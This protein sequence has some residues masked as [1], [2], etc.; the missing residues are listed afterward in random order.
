MKKIAFV[1]LAALLFSACSKDSSESDITPTDG[2]YITT[3]S[4]ADMLISL[5]LENGVCTDFVVYTRCERFKY[6]PDNI[7]TKGEYP[8]YRYYIDDLTI[9]ANFSDLSSFN[10]TLKGIL[11]YAIIEENMQSFGQIGF[12]GK[13]P[14][15]FVLD[16]T[17]LDANG[18]GLLDSKQ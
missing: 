18:D 2:Q 15:L 16:N 5:V 9:Q 10:G 12:N 17:P 6:I 7:S 13:E 3:D 8:K 11:E 14:M 1:L 4:E